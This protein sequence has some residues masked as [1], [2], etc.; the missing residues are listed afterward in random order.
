MAWPLGSIASG[1]PLLGLPPPTDAAEVAG[2]VKTAVDG[3]NQ[4]ISIPCAPLMHGTGLWIGAFI[5]TSPVG[6]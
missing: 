5:P 6:T 4:L 1:F 2:I 3:G